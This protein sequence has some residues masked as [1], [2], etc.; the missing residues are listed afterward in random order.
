MRLAHIICYVVAA[1][2]AA[3]TV[4]VNTAPPPP[5]QTDAQPPECSEAAAPVRKA[6]GA[7]CTCDNQCGTGFCVSGVCCESRCSGTCQAC[8]LANT[9]GRCVAIPAGFPPVNDAQCPADPE[10]SCGNSHLCD[11]K[12][13]CRP[14]PD[15]TVCGKGACSEGQVIG[16]KQCDGG[17]CVDA[18]KIPC[19]PYAC[20]AAQGACFDKCQDDNQCVGRQCALPMGSCGKKAL[21][22]ACFGSDDCESGECTDGVCCNAPCM[23]LCVEC[24]LPSKRGICSPVAD[25]AADPHNLCKDEGIESC[26]AS[27]VCDGNGGCRKYPVGSLCKPAFC[28]GSS[29]VPGAACD[30]KGN[31]VPGAAI[32][33][34]PFQCIGRACASSCQSDVDCLAPATCQT[35]ASGQRSCGA[36]GLG[37]ACKVAA[38]CESKNCVDGVCCDSA[39]QGKCQFC[40]TTSSP[41]R[42][43]NVAAGAPDP[44]AA[45]GDTNPERVCLNQPATSCGTTGTCDGSGGC[46]KHPKTTLCQSAACNPATNQYA[47]ASMCDGNGQCVQ[48]QASTCAPNKCNG[49][50]C[51]QYCNGDVDCVTPAVCVADPR[52]GTKNCGKKPNGQPCSNNDQCIFGHCES[53]VCCLTACGGACR[54]CAT[55]ACLPTPNGQPDPF[56]ICSKMKKDPSTCGFDGLCNGQSACRTY[57]D[58]TVC[59]S[60]ICKDGTAT[61]VSLCSGGKCVAGTSQSCGVYTCGSGGLECLSTCSSDNQCTAGNVCAAGMCGK[62]A[63]GAA[64]TTN[65]ECANGL[66]VDQVCCNAACAGSCK[67]CAVP[68]KEGVCSPIAAG[69]EDPDPKTACVRSDKTSCGTSGVCDG[70]GKCANWPKETLCRAATCSAA[71]P[72][73]LNADAYCSGDGTACPASNSSEC[74]PYL[75]VAGAC[76]RS[77]GSNSECA[78]NTY[79][80]LTNP[81]PKIRNTCFGK[82]PPGAGCAQGG[83]CATGNC[84]DG[85]CCKT[86][87]CGVCQNCAA[88][89]TATPGECVNVSA[90]AVDVTPPGTCAPS[91][92]SCGLTGLCDGKGGCE[93]NNGQACGSV[94]IPAAMSGGVQKSQAALCTANMCVPSAADVVTCGNYVCDK[95]TGACKNG[96]TSDNDCTQNTVCDTSGVG[97][98]KLCVT[99]FV[100]QSG[101]SKGCAQGVCVNSG[102][103]LE[104]GTAMGLWRANGNPT[105]EVAGSALITTLKGIV[106][107]GPG[108]EGDAWQFRS[109]A[110]NGAD[111]NY[112]GVKPAVPPKLTALTLDAWVKK[113]GFNPYPASNRVVVGTDF[114]NTFASRQAM[115]YL[116]EGNSFFFYVQTGLGGVQGVD[117][118]VCAFSTS[119]LDT[120]TRLTASYDGNANVNCFVN[121]VPVSTTQ[122]QNTGV[123]G[124]V[125]FVI[126][127]NFPGDIDDVRVF[128]RALTP[129]EVLT[130]WP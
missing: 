62:K 64:C 95:A 93:S 5:V 118:Q 79:C 74:A 6:Q 4:P 83:Q 124:V 50:A 92:T 19:A 58:G 30:D 17:K 119:A 98:K 41:G 38:E 113:T 116:H 12:G 112:V 48:P 72:T 86:A 63:Q 25:G 2:C 90:K 100:N 99:C 111:P 67:S 7:A 60:A 89:G 39:C 126:G 52:S 3:C 96:C 122:L 49:N 65:N 76:K 32:A 125:D 117:W 55:G 26:G 10:A 59:A 87:V 107:Y 35:D 45:T 101:V 77:C 51:A 56:L 68:G 80:D 24:N 71:A 106:P 29:Q 114:A 42:C 53:G 81:D 28:A 105:N 70:A 91:A 27:G 21:G 108:R 73:K 16:V 23:G 22:A 61:K 15:G 44:R 104:S 78:D 123:I 9:T 69:Q 97:A 85:V 43:V 115:I 18:G 46:Q 31:C 120:W 130:P 82:L 11:G 94:C 110:T 75:C 1:S 8:N 37:Q 103:V 127:R 47:P 57:A 66:C 129:A 121:G 14:Y 36:K 54:S 20:N 13:G 40:A 88:T 34:A 33:C 102:C 109:Q 84:V 128:A